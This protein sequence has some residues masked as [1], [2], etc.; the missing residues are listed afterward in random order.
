MICWVYLWTKG[1]NCP[2]LVCSTPDRW[3]SLLD[4][5]N[6][7]DWGHCSSSKKSM[8]QSR[9][10]GR[11]WLI[12]PFQS[13]KLFHLRVRFN[14]FFVLFCSCSL[15]QGEISLFPCTIKPLDDFYCQDNYNHFFNGQVQSKYDIF[16]WKE[17][18]FLA[19]IITAIGWKLVVRARI[20]L[21]VN[22]FDTCKIISGL[23]DAGCHG[24]STVFIVWQL[25]HCFC[26]DVWSGD[27]AKLLNNLGEYCQGRE[28]RFFNSIFIVRCFFC[29]A[30]QTFCLS[31]KF[32]SSLGLSFP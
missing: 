29:F 11:N 21:L 30:Q 26:D 25:L 7:I 5:N 10:F 1:G 4:G 18:S 8:L 14:D 15:N 23:A 13:G 17:T 16:L 2:I 19:K 12:L 6:C 22:I 9:T 27:V 24:Q 20:W 3:F 31:C 28:F 32:E